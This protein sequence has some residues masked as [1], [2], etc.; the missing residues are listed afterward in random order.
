M[1]SSDL[2]LNPVTSNFSNSKRLSTPDMSSSNSVA[3]T[4][5]N[6][7]YVTSESEFVEP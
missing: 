4:I 7:V 5:I 1:I 2:P 3:H 6:G